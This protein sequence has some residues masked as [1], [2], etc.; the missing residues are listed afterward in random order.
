MG[1]SDFPSAKRKAIP[2]LQPLRSVLTWGAHRNTS[3]SHDR[4]D[5]YQLGQ[6]LTYSET[7]IT[8]PADVAS[9]TEEQLNDLIFTDANLAQASLDFRRG[10]KFTD[11]HLSSGFDTRKRANLTPCIRSCG[12]DF[13]VHLYFP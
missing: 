3:W 10:A 11:A 9:L 5:H 13:L 2:N 6:L 12:V 8:N 7:R 4:L 1:R